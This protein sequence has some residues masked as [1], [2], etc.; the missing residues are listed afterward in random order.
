MAE[1]DIAEKTL[2][3]YPDVT[4][5]VMNVLLFEGKKVV[6][7]EDIVDTN[8]RSQYKIENDLHEET[9]DNL[10][11]W[12][13]N[14]RIKAYIGTE[15]QTESEKDEVIRIFGYDGTSYLGQ[16]VRKRE[17][18]RSRR[19][20]HQK[21]VPTDFVPVMTMILYYGLTHWRYSS[22]L[23]DLLKI[24]N[25]LE[26]WVSDYVVNHVFEIAWLTPEQVKMFES[27]FQVVADYFVQMRMYHKY[28][29]GTKAII[30]VDATLKLMTVLT[31]T[32]WRSEVIRKMQEEGKEITMVSAYAEV[33]KR[34]F[35]KGV[36]EGKA[37]MKNAFTDGET[38]NR[39]DNASRMLKAGKLSLEEISEYTGM[40]VNEISELKKS[41]DL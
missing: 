35:N 36:L 13:T 15:H 6:K 30:H 31:K 23:K 19:V 29:P 41:L 4:A 8:V 11:A 27:D 25:E 24:P 33:E 5:D 3:D 34:G 10:K 12:R 26:P 20:K 9:R 39:K 2:L 28:E 1:K 37:Q 21:I 40:K 38:K 17:K 14:G 7:P 16:V 18:D 32:D 22:H